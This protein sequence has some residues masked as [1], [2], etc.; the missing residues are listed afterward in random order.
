MAIAPAF[1]QFDAPI[2][3]G[4]IA[5]ATSVAG[6]SIPQA[7]QLAADEINAAGGFNG[8]KVQIVSYDDHSTASEAVRAF[9]RAVSI[10]HV[11]AVIA[12]Y[13]S[14]VVLALQPWSGRTKTLLVTPGAASNV[15]TQNIAKDYDHFKYTFEGYLISTSQSDLVCDAAK[16]LL[17]DGS[18]FE[19]GSGHQRGRRLDG[20]AR[21]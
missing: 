20:P 7:A 15:I 6:S 9:Q 5:E 18:A 12:S 1:A 4:V 16:D 8:R 10:D 13:I 19:I 17:V 11:N 21:C 3:I 14:E 2:K